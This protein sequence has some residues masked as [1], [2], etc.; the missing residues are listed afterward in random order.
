MPY[1]NFYMI[2]PERDSAINFQEEIENDN[3]VSKNYTFNFDSNETVIGTFWDVDY[4]CKESREYEK[5]VVT[6]AI[7]EKVRNIFFLFSRGISKGASICYVSGYDSKYASFVFSPGEA[8]ELFLECVKNRNFTGAVNLLTWE[9]G[10]WL[11]VVRRD[12]VF[13][14]INRWFLKKIEKGVDYSK[15]PDFLEV[16]EMMLKGSLSDKTYVNK[17]LKRILFSWGKEKMPEDFYEALLLMGY[18]ERIKENHIFFILDEM[19]PLL[20]KDY[21]K[22]P[23]YKF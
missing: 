15:I 7:N 10:V 9:M 20:W 23:D 19:L 22:C 14:K 16:S 4:Y 11:F 12:I 6:E 3:E 1:F 18:K 2:F 13:E 17:E 21:I 5:E 8:N